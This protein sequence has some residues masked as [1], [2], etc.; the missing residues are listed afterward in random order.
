MPEKPNYDRVINEFLIFRIVGEPCFG[1]PKL[2]TNQR[3]LL[4]NMLIIIHS[5]RCS[6]E[7][8]SSSHIENKKSEKIWLGMKTPHSLY[9]TV[10][11]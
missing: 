11:L 2:I 10:N 9:Q 6:L 3:Q 1:R 4:K 8:F 5:L 7:S